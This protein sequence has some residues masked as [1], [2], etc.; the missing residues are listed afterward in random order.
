[1]SSSSTDDIGDDE[2]PLLFRLQHGQIKE[3]T[4]IIDD[5]VQMELDQGRI[6]SELDPVRTIKTQK[7]KMEDKTSA[8]FNDPDAI[9]DINLYLRR[10]L[11]GIADNLEYR[12]KVDPPD[13]ESADDISTLFYWYRTMMIANLEDS[14]Q[15]VDHEYAI[16][17]L[18]SDR[19]D[20]EHGGAGSD[21]RP[22]IVGLAILSW[23]ALGEILAN[24]RTGR[25]R[26]SMD[27]FDQIENG[28]HSYGYITKLDGND[29]KISP[30][31]RGVEGNNI[32]FDLIDI[33]FCPKTGDPVKF[34]IRN[35][36]GVDVA[37]EISILTN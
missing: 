20:I 28:N 25:H 18:N 6:P 8:V 19:N 11:I 26:Y 12:E 29:T 5:V 31:E 36:D 23:Y 37:T 16:H 3:C 30:F 4:D 27:R 34:K 9:R 24:W 35:K 10:I 15:S 7:E 33:D 17:A 2:S 14:Y 13:I 21:N 32:N 22:D 1:M